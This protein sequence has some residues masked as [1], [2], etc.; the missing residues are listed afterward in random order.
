MEVKISEI[1][2]GMK[3][4]LRAKLAVIEESR[5]VLA[6]YGPRRLA[7]AKLYDDSGVIELDLWGKQQE[8]LNFGDQV[9]LANAYA[10][11]FKGRLHLSIGAEG[12]IEKVSM[13]TDD[14]SSPE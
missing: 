1:A 14:Y 2:A 10:R 7:E 6:R 3:V 4:T 12:S 5:V 8:G 9:K 11:W 13:L